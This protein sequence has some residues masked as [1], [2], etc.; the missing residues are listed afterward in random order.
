MSTTRRVSRF[1]RCFIVVC[2]CVLSAASFAAE[3]AQFTICG[4]AEG[5]KYLVTAGDIGEFVKDIVSPTVEV[6]KGSMENLHRLADGTCDA[7]ISQ[8]DAIAV[9]Q[10]RDPNFKLSVET[11]ATLYPEVVHFLCPRKSGPTKLSTILGV[12]DGIV[13]FV[14]SQDGGSHITWENISRNIKGLQ[15]VPTIFVG[16]QRA[17]TAVT[18]GAYEHGGRIVT[19]C[20]IWVGGV[21]AQLMK[22]ADDKRI[23]LI[24]L[25]LDAIAAIKDRFGKPIYTTVEIDNPEYTFVDGLHIFGG[26]TSY[27]TDAVFLVRTSWADEHEAEYGQLL[28]KLRQLGSGSS[29]K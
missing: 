8:R 21:G 20:M 3:K 6:T 10:A 4:G 25:D 11:A 15:N 23:T 14:G 9:Q 13:L 2:L 19:P 26:V 17:I 5:G 1:F 24:D 18:E 29:K 22:D 12:P 7:G 27:A 16:G 28:K